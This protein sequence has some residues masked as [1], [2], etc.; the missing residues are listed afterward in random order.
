MRPRQLLAV[1]T[2][3]L[4]IRR[5][6]LLLKPLMN[7]PFVGGVVQRRKNNSAVPRNKAW[8]RG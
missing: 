8:D 7:A 2:D 6:Q 5:V 4:S 1:D 3:G